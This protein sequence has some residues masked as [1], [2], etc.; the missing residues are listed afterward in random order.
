MTVTS[1]DG[2]IHHLE[3]GFCHDNAEGDVNSNHDIPKSV[4]ARCNASA[5]V[6]SCVVLGAPEIRMALQKKTNP[7]L[8]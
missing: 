2:D 3:V 5:R 6:P 4:F 8:I 1:D 7:K